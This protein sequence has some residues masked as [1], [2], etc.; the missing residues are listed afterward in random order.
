[1]GTF[2]NNAYQKHYALSVNYVNRQ[3]YI[4]APSSGPVYVPA[5]P[6]RYVK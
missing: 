5:V 3:E 6:D 4:G 2:A 1:M